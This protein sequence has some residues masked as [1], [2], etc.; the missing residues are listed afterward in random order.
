MNFRLI[1]ILHFV[2][3][4]A[5]TVTFANAWSETVRVKM[6]EHVAKHFAN[7]TQVGIIIG[8]ARGDESHFWSFGE[9]S[10]G[11]GLPPS[12]NSFFEMGSITKTFTGALLAREVLEGQVR[13]DTKAKSLWPELD[14]SHAGEITLEQLATHTS[15]LPRL[16]DN[17]APTDPANPY[18]DFNE[19]RMLSFL[20]KYQPNGPGP[21]KHLYSNIGYGLLGFLLSEKLHKD[22]YS[23]VLRR[24]ILAPL[25]LHDTKTKLAPSDLLRA[26]QGYDSFLRPMP[27]W[28][29]GAAEGG[30]V[31]KTTAHDLIAYARANMTTNPSLLSRALELAQEPRVASSEGEARVGLAWETVKIGDYEVLSHSGATGGYRAN[32]LF[33]K[34]EKLAVVILSNTEINPRCVIGPVFQTDCE[35]EEWAKV[36]APQQAELL[37]SYHSEE[38]NLGASVSHEGSILALQIPEQPLIRLFP[39]SPTHYKIL[40]G[41]AEIHFFPNRFELTQSGRTFTFLKK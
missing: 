13:F 6:A 30:G 7:Q 2:L 14:G 35:V 15:G 34:K 40:V 3:L 21:Y 38:L 8:V 39:M 18:A 4:F 28:D 16:P 5:P 33:A 25:S 20:K 24:Q 26:A 22:T 1:L 19:A 36:P 41:K 31:L 12:P 17:L 27:F 32:L 11:S 29:L 9:V 37:G 23:N 10:R